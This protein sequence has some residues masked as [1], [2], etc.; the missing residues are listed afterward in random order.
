MLTELGTWARGAQ[1]RPDAKFAALRRW[2]DPIVGPTGDSAERVIIFTEYRDT[3][4]WLYERFLTAG[5]PA[6]RLAL[7]YGGQDWPRPGAASPLLPAC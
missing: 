7:L 4:R 3:Q 6:Q 1:D 5:Y 2:L